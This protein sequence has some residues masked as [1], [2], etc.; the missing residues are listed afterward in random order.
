MSFYGNITN[1]SRTHFQFDRI[2]AN[3]WEMESNKRE[4]GIYAGRFVLV[5]YDSQ[6]HMDSILRVNKKII[7]DNT[8]YLYTMVDGDSSTETLLTKNNVKKDELVYSSDL[9]KSPEHGYFAKNCVFYKC[10]SDFIAGSTEP[11]TFVEVVD[12]MA[13]DNYVINYNID[14]KRYGRGYD[15][16]VWQKVYV[17]GEEHYLMVAELNTIVPVFALQADAPTQSPIIPHF[18]TESSDLYYKLHY[19]PSWGM[20]VKSARIESGPEFNDKGQEVPNSTTPYSTE[21]PILPFKSDETTLW[22]KEEYDHDTGKTITYYWHPNDGINLEFELVGKLT[23]WQFNNSIYYELNEEGNYSIAESYNSDTEYYKLLNYTTGNWRT[24]K[25]EADKEMPAAIYYNRAGFSSDVISIDKT[26]DSIKIAPTGKSGHQYNKHNGAVN[27]TISQ[28]DIQEISVI[29]PSIGSSVAEMWNVVYGNEEQN[30]SLERNKDIAWDSTNGLRMVRR[31]ENDENNGFTYEPEQVSTL[32]GA[33]NSVHDLMGMIIIN[34]PEGDIENTDENHIYYHNGKYYR[35][36]IKYDYT[37]IKLDEEYIETL[38]SIINPYK[39]YYKKD[40]DSYIQVKEF[41]DGEIYYEL[42]RTVPTEM[43]YKEIPWTFTPFPANKY[44]YGDS[45]VYTLETNDYPTRDRVYI[46]TNDNK[47]MFNMETTQFTVYNKELYYQINNNIS[48]TYYD[49]NKQP[50]EL[51]GQGYINNNEFNIDSMYRPIQTEYREVG[52]I[53]EDIFQLFDFYIKENDNNYIKA[54]EWMDGQIYYEFRQKIDI[55]PSLTAGLPYIPNYYYIY[56]NGEKIDETVENENQLLSQLKL[57][58][59]TERKYNHY[60]TIDIGDDGNI[61]IMYQPTYELTDN[62]YVYVDGQHGYIKCKNIIN[63]ISS[64]LD[65]PEIRF[66]TIQFEDEIAG[67]DFYRPGKYYIVNP[68]NNF[69]FIKYMEEIPQIQEINPEAT[70]S[71]K[72]KYYLMNNNIETIEL[73]PRVYLYDKNYHG[74]YYYYLDYTYDYQLDNKQYVV[75]INKYPTEN[76]KYYI[77]ENFLY[78]K[79][80]PLDLYGKG[81]EWNAQIKVVPNG[82]ILAERKESPEFRELENFARTLNTIHGLILQINKILLTNDIYTRDQRTVQGSINVLNDI[83]AKFEIIAP[84]QIMTVDEY[85]RIHSTPYTTAQEF[86]TNHYQHGTPVNLETIEK[87]ILESTEDRWINMEIDINAE[88]PKISIKHN[89]T[90]VPNT[91]TKSTQDEENTP[92]ELELF[93]PIVD[94]MGHM[95]GHNIE[96]VELPHNFKTITIN[97]NNESKIIADNHVANFNVSNGDR[98][99]GLSIHPDEDT[100]KIYHE[101]AGGDNISTSYDEED[102]LIFGS[103]FNVPTIK[104]DEKGHITEITQ[105]IV[106]IPSLE[107]NTPKG[108]VLTGLTLDVTGNQS[109]IQLTAADIGTLKLGRYSA[110]NL[111]SITKE[112]TLDVALSKLEL[113]LNHFNETL[114]NKI[115]TDINNLNTS[116][117]NKINTDINN[118]NTSLTNKI[119]TDI[120]NLNTQLTGKIDTNSADIALIK[121]NLGDASISDILS[122]L[123]ALEKA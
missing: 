109:K 112:D 36:A 94:N 104:N 70:D 123:E 35:K 93:T 82:V 40:G 32:A 74:K 38:D 100:F 83:I 1:T 85:G 121:A 21:A 33:I 98:W 59:D 60:Y 84:G 117:T 72:L 49:K 69:Q 106:K 90:E 18:D 39:E 53:T 62:H 25:P 8:F 58:E 20:R 61:Y 114:T 105:H 56:K 30:G 101:L 78:V 108:N 79:E 118:L 66:C 122:R 9:E 80:D 19:Q 44:Y 111:E 29:L 6:L 45:D 7:D 92:G 12:G 46:T 67:K 16:T 77:K 5:E 87:T 64:L 81:S 73:N 50:V 119:N 47:E 76:R 115:N 34:N 89:F 17:N 97:G 116:L 95:V 103:E 3:R 22:T 71:D 10:T 42:I 96:T 107:V 28:P 24:Y 48:I 54:T 110:G 37:D 57:S 26:V 51:T 86:E 13:E 31:I 88:N 14:F 120:N 23:Y 91:T 99:I 4:D 65:K 68:D 102:I 55:L 11:A 113:R 75:D 15:S 41:V 52:S 63:K 2:Y 43:G 27:E